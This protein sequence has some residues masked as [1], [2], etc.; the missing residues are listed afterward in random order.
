[1][2]SST[3]IPTI[4]RATLSRAVLS[5]L[6]Q[7]SAFDDFEVIVVND[8][9][10]PLPQTEWQRSEHVRIISTNKRERS[11]ARNTG[12]AIAKGNYLHFLD[13]DDWLA[14]GALRNLMWLA[15]DTNAGWCY[16][17]SQ[18]IDRQGRQ[19][20]QLHHGLS[21]NCFIQI[22]AGEWIPLQ[23]SFI[24][25]RVFFEVGGFN[26]L[27]SGPEDIDLLRRIALHSAIAGTSEPVAFIEMGQEGSSTDYGRHAEAS[28][29]AR[30]LILDQKEAFT[31]MHL[32]AKSS[33]WRGRLV[34][35]YL[36]STAWNIQR[37]RLMTAASRATLGIAGFI[38]TGRRGLSKEFLRALVYKYESDTFEKGLK[39][40]N[41]EAGGTDDKKYALEESPLK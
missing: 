35:V 15:Q 19:L 28:R 9:G 7:K 34:R 13:D 21:G 22:M 8:S 12:A 1:M 17:S 2:F 18:L 31:R 6:D 16:G 40:A 29:F 30:E 32:S 11:V 39:E 27:I 41:L 38:S 3:I 25:S 5:I 4:G 33:Y 24:N 20:L 14:P 23:A 10:N 26:P 37:N 36:T